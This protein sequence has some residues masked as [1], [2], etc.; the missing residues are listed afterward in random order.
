MGENERGQPHPEQT[1]EVILGLERHV[2]AQA[3]KGEEGEQKEQPAD[4][5]ML[6]A[7]DRKNE[8]VVHDRARQEAQFVEGIFRLETL[9]V[10]AAGTDGGEGLVDRPSRALRV[11]FRIE[12]GEDALPLVGTQ[13]EVDHQRDY[14]DDDQDQ[15]DEEARRDPGRIEHG[16][17]DRQPDD[18]RPEVRLRENHQAGQTGDGAAEG[19]A[20]RRRHVLVVGKEERHEHDAGQN[21]QL[22]WLEAHETKVEPATA[23]IN[24][25]AD[26]VNGD[27][28][29][30]SGQ[31]NGQS[32]ASDPLVIE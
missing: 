13:A 25:L 31:V 32:P 26:E 29:D 2:E 17:H 21:G 28:P 3:N 20:Q 6:L 1:T 5:S 14:R 4:E 10:P 22:R 8:I 9:A 16:H 15:S 12:E 27:Q 24:R 7:D 23:P 11:E 18:G 30:Q 19:D